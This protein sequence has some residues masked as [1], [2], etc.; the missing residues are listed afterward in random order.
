MA[1]TLSAAAMGIV[2]GVIVSLLVF[3]DSGPGLETRHLV[4]GLLGLAVAV[5]GPRVLDARRQGG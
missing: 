3:G 1:K 2:V 5:V 4:M